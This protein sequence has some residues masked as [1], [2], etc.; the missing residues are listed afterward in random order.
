[1]WV[2]LTHCVKGES[3]QQRTIVSSNRA[4]VLG[5][6]IQ[7]SNVL[8]VF[9]REIL[10]TLKTQLNAGATPRSGSLNFCRARLQA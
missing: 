8:R 2:N 3:R 4:Q 7:V 5:T 9:N 1:M 10:F 6:C